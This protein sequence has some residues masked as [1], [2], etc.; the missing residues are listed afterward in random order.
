MHEEWG[1][2]Q[3]FIPTPKTLDNFHLVELDNGS[4]VEPPSG[5]EFGWVPIVLEVE[6]PY[7]KYQTEIAPGE[8]P[9]GKAPG[10]PDCPIDSLTGEEQVSMLMAGR[11]S[12][13]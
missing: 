2:N 13:P 7:G 6:I 8:F 4:V 1:S 9:C 12:P 11:V 5:K 3:E 10:Q